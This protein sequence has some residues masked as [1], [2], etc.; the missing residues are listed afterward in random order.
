MIQSCCMQWV[1][2][3]LSSRFDTVKFYT[4]AVL[5]MCSGV[6]MAVIQNSVLYTEYCIL[7]NPQCLKHFPSA[8]ELDVPLEVGLK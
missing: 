1:L 6:V 5:S 3:H 2:K 7:R 8:T 4:R